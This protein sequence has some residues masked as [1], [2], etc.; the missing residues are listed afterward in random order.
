M[1]RRRR[2]YIREYWRPIAK[3]LIARIDFP[4]MYFVDNEDVLALGDE[5]GWDRLVA[6]LRIKYEAQDAY[7]DGDYDLASDLFEEM[8]RDYPD[9]PDWMLWYHGAFS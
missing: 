2:D 5:V 6:F 4:R 7:W 3:Q 1:A 8:M 9:F